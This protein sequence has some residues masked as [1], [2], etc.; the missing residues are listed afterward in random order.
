M[1]K[2]CWCEGSL[3]LSL[4]SSFSRFDSMVF[5]HVGFCTQL[6]LR[7]TTFNDTGRPAR[8]HFSRHSG[9]RP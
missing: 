1:D 2:P 8:S 7:T 5:L 4:I 9:N 6:C 3:S